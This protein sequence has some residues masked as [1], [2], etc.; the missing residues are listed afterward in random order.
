MTIITANKNGSMFIFN[1]TDQL[2]YTY[3]ESV[4]DSQNMESL[5]RT[6]ETLFTENITD[7]RSDHFNTYDDEI[8]LYRSEEDVSDMSIVQNM[9]PEYF[10]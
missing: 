7:L 9:F 8:T 4:W 1:F 5:N 2:L 3:I 10:I 6:N